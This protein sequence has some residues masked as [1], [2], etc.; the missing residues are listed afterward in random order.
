[1]RVVV[2]YKRAT[3]YGREVEEWIQELK[4]RK[5]QDSEIE[6][7]N[8]ETRDGDA[9]AQAYEVVQYPSILALD[10]TGRVLSSWTG[11][12]LPRLDEVAYYLPS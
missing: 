1:M 8:P 9:M 10:D 2:I 5:G 3:D 12:P 11:L 4:V 6:E 7:V